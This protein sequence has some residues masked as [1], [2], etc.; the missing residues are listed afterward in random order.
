MHCVGVLSVNHSI[1]GGKMLFIYKSPCFP[2]QDMANGKHIGK[3]KKP[4]NFP[5]SGLPQKRRIK[6]HDIKSIPVV[7]FAERRILFCADI[8]NPNL[9]SGSNKPLYRFPER[10]GA[11]IMPL[12]ETGKRKN[13][14]ILH[15]FSSKSE[16]I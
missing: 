4:S 9:P 15:Y 12:S 2:D 5:D 16:T 1:I 6:P 14:K 3:A 10:R 8:H 7:P 13:K 11:N